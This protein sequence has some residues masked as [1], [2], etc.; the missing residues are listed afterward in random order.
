MVKDS[1]IGMCKAT[2]PSSFLQTAKHKQEAFSRLL[3][4]SAYIFNK[5]KLTDQKSI[6]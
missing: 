5:N 4:P 2:M 6:Y 3:E 1:V